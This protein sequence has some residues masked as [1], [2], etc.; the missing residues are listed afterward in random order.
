MKYQFV[1]NVKG[2]EVYFKVPLKFKRSLS[3]YS[4]DDSQTYVLIIFYQ[5]VVLSR[6]VRKALDK[7]SSDKAIIILGKIFTQD[8]Q[9]TITERGVNV[10]LVHFGWTDESYQ[11][12]RS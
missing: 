5:D 11:N 6:M 12:I 9:K 3:H 8:A 10:N 1:N 7:V 2:S 4:I